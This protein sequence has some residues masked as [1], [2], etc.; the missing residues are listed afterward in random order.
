MVMY[1]LNYVHD[2]CIFPTTVHGCEPNKDQSALFFTSVS[3]TISNL[4]VG[5][6]I[7]QISRNSEEN[8]TVWAVDYTLLQHKNT[9]GLRL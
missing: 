6:Q 4:K 2:R 3:N 1:L 5:E 8:E 7:N 9:S